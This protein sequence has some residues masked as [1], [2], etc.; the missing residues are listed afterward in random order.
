M[1]FYKAHIKLTFCVHLVFVKTGGSD[2]SPFLEYE[3]I[4]QISANPVEN[5]FQQRRITEIANIPSDDASKILKNIAYT[6]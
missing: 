4:V 5:R 2:K 1:T 3:K 6:S